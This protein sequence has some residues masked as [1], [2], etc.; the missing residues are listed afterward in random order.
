[1][2]FEFNVK[3]SYI[4]CETIK[5]K[6][7]MMKIF[8]L[9]VF[10]FVSNTLFGQIEWSKNFG[11]DNLDFPTIVIERGPNDYVLFGQTKSTTDDISVNYGDF[12]VYI[13]S[14]D[15]NGI[16]T[17]TFRIL[18][19]S[20]QDMIV[21]ALLINDSTIYFVA[22]SIS[23]NAPDYFT[24]L[25]G[26]NV[27]IKSLYSSGTLVSGLA[28]GAGNTDWAYDF[29]ALTNGYII[30]GLTLSTDS[31]FSGP[32]S[33]S[34][35]FIMRFNSS[36]NLVWAYRYGNNDMEEFRE[37][38]ILSDN[39]IF[40]TGQKKGVADVRKDLWFVKCNSVGDTIETYHLETSD[41][42]QAFNVDFRNDSNLYVAGFTE[43]TDGIFASNADSSA[44]I[45]LHYDPL[46]MQLEGFRFYGGNGIDYGLDFMAWND[47]I[48]LLLMC[49]ESN[50]GNFSQNF[51]Q[52]DLFLIA[53]DQSWNVVGYDNLGGSN[54][55]GIPYEGE[56]SMLKTA[57]GKLMI[58]TSSSS[59]DG[60]LPGNYGSYDNWV[61]KY[62][63]AILLSVEDGGQLPQFSVYPNP[64]SDEINIVNPA[65]D[66][67]QV[68]IYSIDGRTCI[69]EYQISGLINHISVSHLTSG[70][71]LVEFQNGKGRSS[72]KIIVE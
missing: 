23:H 62:N 36:M 31:I 11:G 55:D 51:G 44:A 22:N 32:S 1:M 4:C 46:N 58:A 43:T 42:C 63:P 54:I 20:G 45:V 16:L 66:D 18:D 30:V 25:G 49:S 70:V 56:I 3:I 60:D 40:L 48:N 65:N 53:L 72:Q 9:I 2:L 59:S 28:V 21:D 29:K 50:D 41:G 61:I 13:S 47:S 26:T 14:F 39:S 35:A 5:N 69:G 12:D 71:Y 67:A 52:Y 38:S 57:D 37:A 68:R 33:N 17:D 64:V 24:S 27:W 10:L 15:N 6:A 34:D 8:S 19:G 7:I